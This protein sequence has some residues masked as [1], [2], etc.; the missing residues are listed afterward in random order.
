MKAVVPLFAALAAVAACRATT[1][2][3]PNTLPR[4]KAITE[5]TTPE[6]GEP[7]RKVGLA[8]IALPPVKYPEARQTT[9]TDT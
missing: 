5:M 2:R 8:L 6:N 4:N 1:Q 7:S 9:V 3:E